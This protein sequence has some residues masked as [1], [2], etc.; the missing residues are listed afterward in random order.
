[1]LMYR[2][3][4]LRAILQSIYAICDSQVKDIP[5][6]GEKAHLVN[7]LWI[8]HGKPT[9]DPWYPLLACYSVGL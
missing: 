8:K 9:S 6:A 3:W 1:M 7:C 4:E 2:L 5:G